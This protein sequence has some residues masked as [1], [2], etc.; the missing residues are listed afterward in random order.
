MLP[1]EGPEG[2]GTYGAGSARSGERCRPVVFTDERNLRHI[3]GGEKP[4]LRFR[5]NKTG[6]WEEYPALSSRPACAG[7]QGY[8]KKLDK[9]LGVVGVALPESKG[10]V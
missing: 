4:L 6:R 10:R 3:A 2:A 1:A 8:P 7:R 5:V 9:A